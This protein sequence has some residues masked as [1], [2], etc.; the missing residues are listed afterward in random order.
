MDTVLYDV[1][2]RVATV[3]LNRPDRLNAWTPGMAT[4]MRE[5]MEKAAGDTGVRAVVLTG[6]GRG[7]CAGADVGLM[8]QRATGAADMP[9]PKLNRFDYLLNI[10][11]PLI[12]AVNGPAAGIG[13]VAALWCDLRF[14]ASGAKLSTSFARRGLPAEYGSAWLL[15]RL[16]GPMHTADLLLTG[17]ILLAEEA[18]GMGLGRVLP[19]EGFMP[20]VLAVAR[21]LAE[22][23]SPRSMAVI[24]RQMRSAWTQTL[25]QASD[26][27]DTE[28]SEA[29]G[30]D[31][32]REGVRHHLE[33][34]LP[35]FSDPT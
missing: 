8:N 3:T 20:A 28:L 30:T 4:E 31:D 26:L 1:A 34:R 32:Y 9:D 33:R 11:K 21:E 2:D 18:G 23:S 25:A 24:K 29:R 14:L 19:A 16:V 22:L 15:Q 7:F 17:R 5:A 13:L 10:D 35:K 6:A 12:A 27:A